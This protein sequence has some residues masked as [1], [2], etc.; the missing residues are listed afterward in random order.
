MLSKYWKK[1]GMII[2]IVACVFNV[3][4]K[5]INKLSMD[6]EMV[7]SA[8]YVQDNPNE[9]QKNEQKQEKQ[10]TQNTKK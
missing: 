2:V 8:Q 4:I 10:V 5:L 1:I 9:Q 6:K 7:A 3:M